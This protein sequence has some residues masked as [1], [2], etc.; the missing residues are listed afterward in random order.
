M[1]KILFFVA[2]LI[3]GAY[4]FYSQNNTKTV[5]EETSACQVADDTVAHPTEPPKQKQNKKKGKPNTANMSKEMKEILADAEQIQEE[6]REDLEAD[7]NSSAQWNAQEQEVE[8]QI[9]KTDQMVE[10]INKKL[11]ID[12]DA[13]KAEIEQ[14]YTNPV[15]PKDA[16][17]ELKEAVDSTEE[18]TLEI[19][20][21]MD[22]LGIEE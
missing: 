16:P 20:Q 1:K 15:L 19:G 7:Q 17:P 14:E 2:V 12:G 11:G 3:G 5:T 13:I 10:K 6:I 18:T 21:L 8:K 9:A 4:W 22:E